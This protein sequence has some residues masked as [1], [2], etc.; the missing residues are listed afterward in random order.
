MME[1]IIDS[2]NVGDELSL[3]LGK[4]RELLKR[5]DKNF[6][7]FMVADPDAEE[8]ISSDY[9][10]DEEAIEKLTEADDWILYKDGHMVI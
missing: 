9:L 8:Y 6:F 2:M 1:R 10:N 7:H 3:G 4:K 5:L